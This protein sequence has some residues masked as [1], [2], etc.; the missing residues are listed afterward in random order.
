MGLA[1]AKADG[2]KLGRPRKIISKSRL[3]KNKKLRLAGL[4]F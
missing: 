4:I 2:K 3:K 1:K